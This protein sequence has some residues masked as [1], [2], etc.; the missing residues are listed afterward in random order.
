M[1]RLMLVCALVALAA[2]PVGAQQTVI[3]PTK[4]EFDSANHATNCPADNCVASYLVELWLQGVDPAS[5]A[6]VTSCTVPKTAVT[7]TGVP[8]PMYR[9]LFSAC[10][11]IL[12]APSGQILVVRMVAAGDFVNSA[13]S[14]ASNPFVKANPAASPANLRV[15]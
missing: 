10:T 4:V 6:P 11:P 8:S 1:R 7:Q 3:N 12:A 13:R 14:G 9:A 15:N 5:G 2:V